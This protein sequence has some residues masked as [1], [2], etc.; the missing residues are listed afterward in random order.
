[1]V[2]FECFLLCTVHRFAKGR[3]G[4]KRCSVQ[5]ERNDIGCALV[6]H[7]PHFCLHPL[8]ASCSQFYYPARLT[9]QDGDTN[10]VQIRQ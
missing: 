3:E 5:D 7:L 8:Q 6:H 2:C 1:M 4:I 9:D 10:T